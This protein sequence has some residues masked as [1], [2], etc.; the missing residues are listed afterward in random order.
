M[1]SSELFL[2]DSLIEIDRQSD[3]KWLTREVTPLPNGRADQVMAR[4][5]ENRLFI[6]KGGEF[7]TYDF[8]GS[9]NQVTNNALPA[10]WHVRDPEVASDGRWTFCGDN[11]Y[12]SAGHFV[13]EF[14]LHTAERRYLVPDRR[15][16]NGYIR[17][18]ASMILGFRK[19]P[20]GIAPEST[21]T[22]L[23]QRQLLAEKFAFYEKLQS[24]FQA[25][26]E[27]KRG[28]IEHCYNLHGLP[29]TNP[30]NIDPFFKLILKNS[31]RVQEI[32]FFNGASPELKACLT[33][34]IQPF[35]VSPFTDHETLT[36]D[37]NEFR[38]R[39]LERTELFQ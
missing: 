22:L 28:R 34:I 26:L 36:V 32:V 1:A 18:E 24:E 29:S 35:Q 10:E 5:D 14:N 3:G 16:L 31:G 8:G 38:C 21:T 37:V 20:A 30:Q 39:I 27:R 13:I 6:V 17:W 19:R 4:L 2:R 7:F 33:D 23:A 9:L 15:F 25:Q 12:L 11:F